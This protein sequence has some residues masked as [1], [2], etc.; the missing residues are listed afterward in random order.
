[1]EYVTLC[2]NKVG[3][4][5]SPLQTPFLKEVEPGIQEESNRLSLS[6]SIH[7]TLR[8]AVES[9]SH[10]FKYI[11]SLPLAATMSDNSNM[12]HH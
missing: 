3:D 12:D 9:H 5:Q 11:T 4:S 7:V 2:S 8:F 6:L 1:M 10:P